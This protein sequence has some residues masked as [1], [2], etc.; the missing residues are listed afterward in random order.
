M[1]TRFIQRYSLPIDPQNDDPSQVKL[2]AGAL[3]LDRENGKMLAQVKY[4]NLSEKAISKITVRLLAYDTNGKKLDGVSQFIYEVSAQSNE[5]FGE[6]TPILLPDNSTAAF[7]VTVMS[8]SF[9]DGNVWNRNEEKIKEDLIVLKNQSVKVT[10]KATRLTANIL[11]NI[12][13]VIAFIFA[14][15]MLIIG[16]PPN[17]DENIL[18]ASIGFLSYLWPVICL[19]PGMGKLLFHRFNWGI[20]QRWRA[21]LTGFFAIGFL[22]ALDF[23]KP[24]VLIWQIIS[25]LLCIYLFPATKNLLFRN[26]PYGT[27]QRLVYWGMALGFFALDVCFAIF[28]L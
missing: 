21:S 10:K 12:L 24:A 17:R 23:G 20:L 6:K 8:I 26:Q 4:K 7:R 9:A 19:C 22:S 2:V 1:N 16:Y 11:M 15:L 25:F 18:R 14:V 27:K 28:S 13:N 5:T 3:L